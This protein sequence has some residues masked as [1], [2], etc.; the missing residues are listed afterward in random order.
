MK[1]FITGSSIVKPRFSLPFSGG[2]I[3]LLG[4]TTRLGDTGVAAPSSAG[5]WF[6]IGVVAHVYP[7]DLALE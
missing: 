6:N 5:T 2:F 7:A 1:S 4:L 3:I